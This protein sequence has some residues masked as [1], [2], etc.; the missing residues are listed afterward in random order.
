MATKMISVKC[1]SCKKIFEAREADVKRGWGK[2]C[3]KSCKAKKQ[4]K[5]TGISRPD[6]RASG[7]TVQQMSNGKYNK[8][9][10]TTLDDYYDYEDGELF[11]ANFSNEDDEDIED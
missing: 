11:Y 6:F 9:S 5:M 3:S 2:F 1:N 10:S 7:R 4:F 8:S